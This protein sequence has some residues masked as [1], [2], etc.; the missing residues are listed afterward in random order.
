MAIDK[1]M[2]KLGE[3]AKDKP[4]AL[5]IIAQQAALGVEALVK[6]PRSIK[7]EERL[8]NN[9]PPLPLKE[10]QSPRSIKV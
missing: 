1:K 2:S 10:R 4:L 7:V 5:V 9:R 3:W 8:G 6:W